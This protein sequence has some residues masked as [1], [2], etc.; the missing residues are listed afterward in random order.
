MIHD[1]VALT[2]RWPVAYAVFKNIN[3]QLYQKRLINTISLQVQSNCKKIANYTFSLVDTTKEAA[4]DFLTEDGNV[5]VDNKI[6][7]SQTSSNVSS[8][9]F[10]ELKPY[11]EYTAIV[12][13][14][15]NRMYKETVVV[16]WLTPPAS[17]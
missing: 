13:V 15:N 5:D 2:G 11:K 1:N 9:S 4:E 10:H 12:T 14:T 8:T 3:K 16:D 7:V 17:K 6:I